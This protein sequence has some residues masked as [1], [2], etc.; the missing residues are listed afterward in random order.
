MK[1]T[2]FI[3]VGLSLLFSC[4]KEAGEGGTSSIVGKVITY[5]LRH[6]DVPGGSQ[7]VDTLSIYAKAD[8]E[9]FIVY[10]EEDNR[11]DDSYNTSWDGSFSFENLRK[12]KYTIFV[13]SECE[14]DT[15]GLAAL[16]QT[17]PT[18]AQEL[19]STIWQ[20]NCVNGDFPHIVEIEITDNHTVYNLGDIS[21]YNIAVN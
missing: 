17:N 20:P 4:Q 5:D 2:A 1:K 6:F 15:S 11:Y 14:A 13:Y 18:Y 12:G 10:G 9:V 16:S 19:A 8:E 3:L 21:I 7:S